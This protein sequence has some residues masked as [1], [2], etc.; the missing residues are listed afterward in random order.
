MKQRL[1]LSLLMLMVSVGLVKADNVPIKVI[2]PKG[3]EAM[4]IFTSSTKGF[5]VSGDAAS[6]PQIKKLDDSFLELSAGSNTEKAVYEVEAGKDADLNLYIQ[7]AV[8]EEDPDKWGK[9]GIEVK[10]KVAEFTINKDNNGT[11]PTKD[12]SQLLLSINSI[13]FADASL[14][15]IKLGNSSINTSYLPE[16]TTLVIPDNQLTYIPAKTEKMSSYSVGKVTP[17]VSITGV[18]DGNPRSLTLTAEALTGLSFS[19]GSITGSDLIITSLTT[20]KDGKGL[21]VPFKSDGVDGVNSVWHFSDPTTGIYVDADTYYATIKIRDDHKAYGGVE[22][23]NVPIKLVD[24]TFSL[25]KNLIVDKSQ[26]NDVTI[27]VTRNGS[28]ITDLTQLHKGDRIELI[29][30][31]KVENG[32]AFVNFTD[33]KGLKVL[34]STEGNRYVYEVIGNVDPTIKANF[35][36]GDVKVTFNTATSNGGELTVYKSNGGK[37]T[38]EDKLYSGVSLPIGTEITIVADAYVQS[39]Y[40]LSAITLN[41]VSI[42]DKNES[43]TDGHFVSTMTLDAKGANIKAWFSLSNMKLTVDRTTEVWTSFDIYDANSNRK[44]NSTDNGDGTFSIKGI[45][46]GTTLRIEMKLKEPENKYIKEIIL[47]GSDYLTRCEDLGEGHYVIKYVWEN[48]KNVLLTVTC[49]DLLDI[50]PT[51]VE[52]E[53]VYN[54]DYQD[55]AFTIDRT[56]VPLSEIEVTYR[57]NETDSYEESTQFKEVGDYY[58][59]FSRPQKAPYKKLEKVLSYS[60]EQAPLYITGTPVVA[61]VKEGTTSVYKIS[62]LKAQYYQN[63]KLVPEEG[64]E[65]VFTVRA[66][67]GDSDITN[68]V[69]SGLEDGGVVNIRFEAAD[70]S[71]FVDNG[72]IGIHDVAYGDAKN[73]VAIE[74]R[75]T[76]DLGN[77]QLI[78]RSKSGIIDGEAQ[79]GT[80]ITFEILNPEQALLDNNKYHVYRVDN[81]GEIQDNGT[82]YLSTGYKVNKGTPQVDKLIF[83]LDV[84]GRK[85][86]SLRDNANMKVEFTYDGNVK[87]FPIDDTTIFP[88]KDNEGGELTMGGNDRPNVGDWTI[89]Y[90]NSDNQIVQVPKNVDTYT[91][92]LTRAATG[93]YYEFKT[94]GTLIINKAKLTN[95]PQPTASRVTRGS[96]LDDSSLDA[97]VSV[98]GYY[99]WYDEDKSTT[100]TQTRSFVPRFIPADSNYET[101]EELKAVEV[102]VTDEAVLS[103][104]YDFG[105]VSVTD[106]AGNSYWSGNSVPTGTML[107][108]T[109]TPY[110]GFELSSLTKDGQSIANGSSFE[111]VGEPVT[112]NATFTVKVP[113]VPEPEEPDEIIDPNS[114]YVVTVEKASKNNRGFILGKE[115]DNGVYYEDAFEFTVYALDED[116][117]KLVVNGATKIGKGKYRISSVTDNMTVTV[118]LPNPTQLDVKVVTESKNAKGY[119]VGK[120]KA[121]SYPADGKC[122]YGDELV[123]VAYPVDGVSFSYWRDNALNKDQMREITVTKDMTIEAVFSGVPTGIEDIESAGIYAGKGYIQVKNVANADLTVVSISGRIQAQQHLDGDVQVRVP[124]G[125]Y[126]VVLEN[127][128]DVK[129]VKVIVR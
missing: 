116:L 125:V 70:G 56:D 105:Y 87:E 118:S 109:A 91:V 12:D 67:E 31:P 111:F 63:G 128:Q 28:E 11:A 13:K 30:Q 20:E 45:K 25:D 61:V 35:A 18:T 124:A 53:L 76:A 113:E 22:I 2:I 69:P 47:N 24:A 115:G 8:P 121:E 62:G 65:G 58:V 114:Q 72:V 74:A 101:Y 104:I 1:L 81:Q 16:L 57:K 94:T 5:V 39:D 71:N 10:G 37:Y 34:E 14:E 43:E 75:E 15:W 49:E 54:G 44:Y 92:E 117:D 99:D 41:D 55:V 90:R 97:P 52:D 19:S 59:V 112:I 73:T 42:L 66:K 108:V 26:G 102:Q 29:P 80:Q 46:A 9:V 7:T 107:T 27:K 6:Y 129:R 85:T 79:D 48:T 110:D 50:T 123:V 17:T 68:A 122:Y 3:E 4:I 103:I 98:L 38:G 60:I 84:D 95:I 93:N 78:M 120:V 82:D 51:L 126:V 86:L 89:V 100:L 33:I 36:T 127:G 106:A 119:L 23:C 64:V 32:Y 77:T 40:V 83:R 88:L 96:R 21:A